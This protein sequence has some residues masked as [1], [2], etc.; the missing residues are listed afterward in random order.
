M[1]QTII[2]T[3][4]V[5]I[6]K[7]SAETWGDSAYARLCGMIIEANT[8]MAQQVAENKTDLL[9]FYTKDQ[10][11]Q[12]DDLGLTLPF[13]AVFYDHPDMISYLHNRGLDLSKTCD[14]M[15]F[16]NPMFYAVCLKKHRIMRRLDLLGYSVNS[17][18]DKFKQTPLVH[19]ERMDDTEIRRTVSLCNSKET[20]AAIL[21]QKHF[22]R[23]KYRRL[24]LNTRNCIIAVQRFIREKQDR[25][26]KS[27]VNTNDK[28]GKRTKSKK[29]SKKLHS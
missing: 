17:E 7:A 24:Y 8:G 16:G 19:A 28:T 6:H 22:L 4:R 15:E 18:C 11:E 14:P 12:P 3:E 29:K 25:A 21:F 2:S 13:L 20:R 27:E 9:D 1:S 10:L 23:R 26:R 5:G